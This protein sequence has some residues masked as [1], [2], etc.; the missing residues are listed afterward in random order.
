ML[1]VRTLPRQSDDS[2]SNGDKKTFAGKVF[3]SFLLNAGYLAR[4]FN[5]S[6]AGSGLPSTNSKKAPPQ[7]NSVKTSMNAMRQKA[8]AMVEQFVSTLT[9]LSLALLNALMVALIHAN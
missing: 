5:I 7:S 8:L 2:I 3:I 4:C 6:T 9:D 1:S